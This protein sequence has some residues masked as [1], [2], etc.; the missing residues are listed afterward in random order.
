MAA[1]M[2]VFATIS[3]REKFISGYGRAAGELVEKFGGRYLVRAPGAEVLEGELDPGSSV[4][5]SEWPDK[6]AALRFWN[7]DEYQAVKKLREGIANAHVAI[8][9]APSINE[10]EDTQQ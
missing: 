10:Q 5:I 9:E 2:I 8:V 3:D 1:Y 6:D 7:S 4:V